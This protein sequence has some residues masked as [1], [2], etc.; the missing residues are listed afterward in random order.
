VTHRVRTWPSRI[1]AFKAAG[2]P[3][4]QAIAELFAFSSELEP[5]S[6]NDPG[7][8]LHDPCTIA[9]LIDPS[10]F[11]FK[12]SYIA[13]ETE[14]ALTLGH[15]QVEFRKRGDVAYTAN[16]AVSADAA[17]LFDMLLDRVRR[18]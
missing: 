17:R 6:A 2:T 12:P 3:V 9:Y 14:G 1:A 7:A 11:A 5:G 10:L 16:W 8:P 15:S 4:T 18:L 13:V